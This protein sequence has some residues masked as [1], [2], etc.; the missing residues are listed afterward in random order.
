VV[1]EAEEDP[2]RRGQPDTRAGHDS[3]KESDAYLQGEGVRRGQYAVVRAHKEEVEV[4]KYM[5]SNSSTMQTSG[6]CGTSCPRATA[7]RRG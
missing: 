2:H 3:D 5:S 6:S 4:K 1:E 7:W